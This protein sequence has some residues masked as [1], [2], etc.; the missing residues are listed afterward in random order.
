MLEE[1][2]FTIDSHSLDISRWEDE[3]GPPAREEHNESFPAPPPT[4]LWNQ[5]LEICVPAGRFRAGCICDECN[6]VR[7]SFQE[8]V[9][10]RRAYARCSGRSG[11]RREN[12][13]N[14]PVAAGEEVAS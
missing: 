8:W 5:F 6:A 7:A 13:S 2:V 12:G 10:E 4:S 9:D 3:G 11:S 14:T 1:D